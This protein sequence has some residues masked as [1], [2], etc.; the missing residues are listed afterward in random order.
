MMRKLSTKLI[1]VTI[2]VAVT[3]LGFFILEESETQVSINGV[4]CNRSSANVWLAVS[5]GERHSVYSLPPGQCTDFFKQDAEA[6]WG[7]DC[8]TDPCSYQAWKL[9]AGRFEVGDDPNSPLGSVLRIQG[10]GAGSR[11]H[12]TEDWPKPELASIHYSLVK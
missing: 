9:G 7:R 10:W 8:S 2:L 3:G 1:I 4:L 6:I 5:E 11:W 12:I